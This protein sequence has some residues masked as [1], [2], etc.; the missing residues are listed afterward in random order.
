MKK[1]V[2]ILLSLLICAP[3]FCD[4]G[5][6]ERVFNT[7]V[8]NATGGTAVSRVF[9]AGSCKRMGYW[10]KPTRGASGGQLSYD[11]ILEGSYDT[12]T[13]HFATMATLKNAYT[14]VIA[15]AETI[16]CPAM[17]YIRFITKG[18]ATN[19]TDNTITMYLYSQ[20]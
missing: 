19:A 1:Y 2:L 13:T 8:V 11:L 15:T 14:A 20:E 18:A 6:I 5:R 17:K 7:D 9:N 12:T 16:T 3:A 10:F 4:E